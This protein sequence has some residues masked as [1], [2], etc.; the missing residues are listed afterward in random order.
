MNIFGKMHLLT[1]KGLARTSRDPQKLHLK[2]H[3][4]T[5]NLH[6]N[7][8]QPTPTTPKPTKIPTQQ[9]RRVSQD[10]REKMNIFQQEQHAAK[11]SKSTESK[12]A[13]NNPPKKNANFRNLSSDDTKT[14]TSNLQTV[15]NSD[16]EIQPDT[17]PLHR[18]SIIKTENLLNVQQSSCTTPQ[19][20]HTFY[21]V[22]AEPKKIPWDQ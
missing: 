22:S 10:F 5:A 2:L 21:S 9:V 1:H 15:K 16:V 14:A 8:H 3:L 11:N 7:Q 13:N 19:Q 18:K 6:P 12:R 4:Q 17:T 20:D